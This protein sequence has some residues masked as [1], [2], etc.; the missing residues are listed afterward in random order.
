M[1]VGVFNNVRD[2]LFFWRNKWL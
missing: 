2:V 1:F